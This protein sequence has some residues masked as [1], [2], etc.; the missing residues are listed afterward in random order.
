MK[1]FHLLK[2]ESKLVNGIVKV[3]R[4]MYNETGRRGGWLEFEHNLSQ[5]GTCGVLAESVVYGG[6]RVMDSAETYGYSEISGRAVIR[7]CASVCDN[8]KI[9]EMVDVCGHAELGGGLVLSGQ[10]KIGGN[11]Y[12]V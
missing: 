12:S 10:A 5:D 6:A 3:Y 1:K 2:N 4:I 9:F 7:E 8:V 11:S